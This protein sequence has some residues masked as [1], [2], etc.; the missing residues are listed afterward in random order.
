MQTSVK[1]SALNPYHRIQAAKE[2]SKSDGTTHIKDQWVKK[3]LGMLKLREQFTKE[4]KDQGG[5]VFEEKFPFFANLLNAYEDDR[6]GGDR[7]LLEAS[8][9]CTVDY[10]AIADALNNPKFTPAF[11]A[12]YSALFFD[13]ASA[14]GNPS[15]E[16]QLFIKPMLNANTDKLAIGHI[17]KLLAL[18]GG[19][20]LFIRKGVG[21]API[22]A[23][24][25]EHLLQ[26]AGFRHC[27]NLLQYVSMGSAFFKD[28]PTA[29]V[30]LT[31]LA[32]FDSI[33]SSSRRPD[34]L[35]TISDVS[36]N[37][38]SSVLSGEL[39]L[40]SAPAETIKKLIDI[41]GTF[42]PDAPGGVEYMKHLTFISEDTDN[43][44]N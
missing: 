38:F 26:L 22:R 14:I 20:P 4:Y 16:F 29:A 10:K 19:L 41:D 18:K 36:K 24:D 44:D 35:A 11:L 9:L 12:V 21:T 8:L 17:W 42:S 32:D 27:S 3:L 31:S 6:N 15:M 28:N 40:I 23:E 43:E 33:R 5:S 1:G 7:D 34:F 37:N 2:L 39:K 13:I 30:A 25:I